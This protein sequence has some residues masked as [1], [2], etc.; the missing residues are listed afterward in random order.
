MSI[1]GVYIDSYFTLPTDLAAAMRDW[2][3]FVEGEEYRVILADRHEQVETS[4]ET[5]DGRPFVL[6]KGRGEG[7]LFFRALGAALFHLAQH[8]DD[9]WPRVMQWP[10]MPGEL[11]WTWVDLP[12]RTRWSGRVDTADC[13]RRAPARMHDRRSQPIR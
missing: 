10:E 6:V 9:V 12:E 3:E 11:P 13:V 7:L 5:D 1:R 2:P 4:L 8:S